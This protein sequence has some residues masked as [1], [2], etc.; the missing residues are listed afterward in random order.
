MTEYRFVMGG[1]CAVEINDGVESTNVRN[2]MTDPI[3]QE[4]VANGGV[5][6][7][8]IVEKPAKKAGKAKKGAKRR[9][10]RK[11]RRSGRSRR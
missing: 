7:N 3:Y 10:S 8:E 11:L 4:W 5:T 2:V 9:P 6:Q 1:I